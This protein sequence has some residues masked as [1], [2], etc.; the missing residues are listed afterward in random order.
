VELIV[1]REATGAGVLS[2]VPAIATEALVC[3]DAGPAITVPSTFP[4]TGCCW[5]MIAAASAA[6]NGSRG[7]RAV[8]AGSGSMNVE[9]DII[10]PGVTMTFEGSLDTLEAGAGRTPNGLGFPSPGVLFVVQPNA[11]NVPVNASASR[12][13]GFADRAYK[14]F[15]VSVLRMW[16][17]WSSA[18]SFTGYFEQSVCRFRSGNSRCYLPGP[19]E[20]KSP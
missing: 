3:G 9:E 17:P 13:F 12:I 7:S 19:E 5:A 14:P 11:V 6:G 1:G 20:T 18:A 4:V 8:T 10:G 2:C 16:P 15:S